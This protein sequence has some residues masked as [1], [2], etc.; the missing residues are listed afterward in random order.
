MASTPIHFQAPSGLTLTVHIFAL[1]PDGEIVNTT[2]TAAAEENNAKSH[3]VCVVTES[4]VGEF[5]YHIKVGSKVIG[6]GFLRLADTPEIHYAADQFAQLNSVKN[7][8][9]LQA[10]RYIDTAPTPWQ[11]V[12][13]EAGTGALGVGNELLRQDLKDVAGAG[14][15]SIA[16][17]VGQQVSP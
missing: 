5:R 14:L 13:V 17:F 4:L 10:D 16:T 8:A 3:Y 1:S 7:L 2:S 15:T 6:S 12:L 9:M 11:L